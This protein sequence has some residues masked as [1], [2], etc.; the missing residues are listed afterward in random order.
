MATEGVEGVGKAVDRWTGDE[1]VEDRKV[2]SLHMRNHFGTPQSALPIQ[3]CPATA[4][5]EGGGVRRRWGIILR[6]GRV[7]GGDGEVIGGGGSEVDHTT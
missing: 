5:S 4:R 3:K 7:S 6:P 1:V 2:S